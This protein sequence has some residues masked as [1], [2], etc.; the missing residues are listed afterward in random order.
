MPSRAHHVASRRSEVTADRHELDVFRFVRVAVINDDALVDDF[1]SD[2]AR[3][4]KARGR[5][6]TIP[7]LMN[8]MSAFRTLDL[9]RQRWQDIAA[10]ARRRRPS[11][12][13]KVGEHIAWVVLRAGM[14]FAYED[15]GHDDGH[16]TIWGDPADLAGAVVE[17][18]PAEV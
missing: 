14:G 15:L 11:E 16:M 4:K 12:P 5:S 9:A 7:D 8:G 3:G 17:I 10:M 18:V 2:A 1:L 6:A 13:I